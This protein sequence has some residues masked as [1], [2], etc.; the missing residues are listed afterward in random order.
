MIRKN[1]AHDTQTPAASV[2][3]TGPSTLQKEIEEFT[4]LEKRLIAR[5]YDLDELD[6][7]NP[8][9]LLDKK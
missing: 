8:Y 2:R 7:D 3:Y 5:G 1:P 6:K 4:E 9:N